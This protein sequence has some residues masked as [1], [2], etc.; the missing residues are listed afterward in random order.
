M[1]RNLLTLIIIFSSLAASAQKLLLMDRFNG[2]KVVN[3]ST[4]TVFSTDP[5]IIDLT[6]YFTMKNNSDRPLALFLRKQVNYIADSTIDYFC[7]GISCWPETDTTNI[8]DTVQPGAEDITFASHVVHFRRFELPPLPAGKTSIT[9]TV[10]DTTASDPVEAS[11]TVIYHLSGVGINEAGD[12]T[13]KV[14]PNPATDYLRIP[15]EERQAALYTINLFDSKGMLV[16]QQ[17]VYPQKDGIL[18]PVAN[19]RNGYYFGN[20][21]SS[22]SSPLTFRFSITR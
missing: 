15:L 12:Q 18:L 20:L 9:Y 10:Y 14:Y 4:I 8:A 1:A 2:N 19:L 22:N 16:S 6:I 21:T 7:F 13:I 3:D 5:S 17:R 11:V